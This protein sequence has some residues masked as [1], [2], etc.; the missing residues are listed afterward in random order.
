MQVGTTLTYT[1]ERASTR[2]GLVA[3]LVEVR[4]TLAALD[5]TATSAIPVVGLQAGTAR[6]HVDAAW[7]AVGN[8]IVALGGD[9][10]A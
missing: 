8:A 1:A 9:V 10:L 6:D 2:A 3:A 5:K 7:R 4:E